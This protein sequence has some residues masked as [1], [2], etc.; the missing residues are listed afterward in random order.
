MT[1]E[2]AEVLEKI[3]FDDNDNNIKSIIERI[4]TWQEIS[5]YWFDFGEHINAEKFIVKQSR[6]IHKIKGDKDFYEIELGYKGQ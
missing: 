4:T 5:E 6:D 3:K 2:A 1:A